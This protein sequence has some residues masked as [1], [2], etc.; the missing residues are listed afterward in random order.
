MKSRCQL[1]QASSEGSRDKFSL[2]SSQLLVAVGNPWCSLACS[3]SLQILPPSS[4][5]LF[6]CVCLHLS[7]S[8]D[9]LLIRTPVLY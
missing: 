2:A 3:S 9:G 7:V 4:H 1:G 8:S 5:G 6:L